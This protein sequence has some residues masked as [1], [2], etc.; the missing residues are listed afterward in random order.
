M[1]IKSTLDTIEVEDRMKTM[2]DELEKTFQRIFIFQI[3]TIKTSI[4]TIK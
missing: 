1:D 3:D 2:K 4:I